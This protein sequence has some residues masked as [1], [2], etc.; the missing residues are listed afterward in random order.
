MD[1]F[2]TITKPS[3]RRVAGVNEEKIRIKLE[4]GSQ[5]TQE[6]VQRLESKQ[7]VQAVVMDFGTHKFTDF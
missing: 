6:K 4:N 1:K 2:V 7:Y 3:H 5:P